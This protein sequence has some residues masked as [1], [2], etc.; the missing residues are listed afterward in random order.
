L[1]TN[2]YGQL[3]EIKKKYKKSL[4][5]VAYQEKSF[6]PVNSKQYPSLHIE[7]MVLGAM[8]KSGQS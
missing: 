3:R 8:T 7:I 4:L 1:P 6:Y 5:L 2:I